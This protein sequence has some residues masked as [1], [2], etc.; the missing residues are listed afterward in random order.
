MVGVMGIIYKRCVGL[1]LIATFIS[2]LP[3]VCRFVEDSV[4]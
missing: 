2:R 1:G 4:R 3:I